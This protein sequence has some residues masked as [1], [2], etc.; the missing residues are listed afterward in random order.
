[1]KTVNAVFEKSISIADEL[2]LDS[3]VLVFDLAFYA[4]AQQVRWHNSDFMD[5]TVVR[6]GEFHTCMSLLSVIGKRFL[7]SGLSDVIFEA[8]VIAQGSLQSVMKGRHYNRSVRTL[9]IVSEALRR[10]QLEEFLEFLDDAQREEF[11]NISRQL[12]EA[13]PQSLFIE[14]VDSPDFQNFER[15]FSLHVQQKCEKL[16]T[17]AFWHSY[18][19]MAD[20]LLTF[21]RATREGDWDL[22]LATAAKMLPWY[23]SYNHLNYARYLPVYLSE[24]GC[25]QTTHPSVAVSLPID[26]VVQQQDRHAFSQTA[27]D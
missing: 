9:K 21:V 1:M 11:K 14:S 8:E 6:L 20:L 17:Y 10:L 13:F 16:P 3:I 15:K 19:E 24:M 7:D 22:H 27:M 12:R 26:F 25:L 2:E 4:K 18:L 23:F 5:R